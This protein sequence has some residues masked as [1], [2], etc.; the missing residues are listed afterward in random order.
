MADVLK[1]VAVIFQ[2]EDRISVVADGIEKQFQALGTSAD[3]ASGQVGDLTDAIEDTGKG[4]GAVDLLTDSMKAL[5][6]SLV[7]KDFID[8]NVAAEQFRKTME[9]ATGDA[10]KA[11]QEFDYVREVSNRLG[12]EARTT[13]ESYASFSAA[14]KGTAL[15][16]DGARVIFEA[17]TGTM[18]RLG[19]SSADISGAFVQ[20]AQGVSKG[21]FELEDLKSIAERVPG[22][23]QQFA[24]S[25]GITTEA[26]YDNISAGEIGG[27]EILVFANKLNQ[28][29]QD[30][31]FDGFTNSLARLRNAVDEA[32]VTLGDA[33]V[34]DVLIKG[35][36]L[37]TASVAGVVAAF[38]FLGETWA[39]II[40]SV[41]SGDWA[42]FG[43]RLEESAQKGAN[44]TRG[45]R[46]A[47][48][49]VD[50][51]TK[52][53]GFNAVEAG[54]RLAA[55]LGSGS[56]AAAKLEAAAKDVDKQLKALGVDPKKLNVEGIVQAFEE[57]SQNPA[58]RGDQILSGLE[59]AIKR[60][61]DSDSLAAV[62]ADVV[63][64]FAKGKLTAEE[65]AKATDLLNAAQDKLAS[66]LDKSK[67]SA[68][69]QADE[70]KRQEE[71][72]RKAEQAARDYALEMEKIASN[73][74]IKLIEAR[75]ALNVAEVEAQTERIKAAF[76]SITQTVT[77]TGDVLGD[78]F[79]LFANYS[80]LDWAAIRAIESQ[81]D[82]EN[83]RR[84]EA[85]DIQKRLIEAQIDQI[86]AQTRA[87]DK[88]DALI[89]VDGSGLQPH[90]EA[91]MWEILKAV[92]VRV[93]QDGLQMLL[94]V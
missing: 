45:A 56:D 90:L 44:A 11:A 36:E 14:V 23:F 22:F 81:I 5:A 27:D 76:E 33:G 7:V 61:K 68:K 25:L 55:G 17:F 66:G 89:Q 28:A 51:A 35:I 34:F 26:L 20:L 46:D 92:Q 69:K 19:A 39:N 31:D 6:A 86:K 87:L 24:D 32:F 8:A 30:A 62:A 59:G 73:E 54:E 13:A 52:S 82:L 53:I 60:I 29:L 38:S 57:L 74:R 93:N 48:L 37:A 47:L 1:S 58:V 4:K 85:L 78:L 10:T 9:V 43:D 88:G 41:N 67:D 80:D 71:A 64:A 63:T 91:F 15:E 18:S 65:F 94:G 42:G 40:Y 49:E 12:V 16:G 72:A 50:D 2:G 21:K 3:G 75:V 79:G 70:L 84:Q 77:S 83:K